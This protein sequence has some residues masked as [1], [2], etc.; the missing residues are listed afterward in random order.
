MFNIGLKIKQKRKDYNLT[1]EE[2]AEKLGVSRQTVS[3]WENDRSLPDIHSLLLFCEIFDTSLDELLREESNDSGKKVTEMR[4][5]ID[6][7][8]K[9]IYF[10][11]C[12]TVA[13]G[14]LLVSQR[15]KHEDLVAAMQKERTESVVSIE[16]HEKNGEKVLSRELDNVKNPLDFD[17]VQREALALV[18]QE[19]DTR[20]AN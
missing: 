2:V 16:V 9:V 8:K 10:L 5:R 6:I 15:Y 11:S 7:Q 18:K 3:K 17:E 20:T 14:L 13:S 12:A 19:I 4:K 1:Q